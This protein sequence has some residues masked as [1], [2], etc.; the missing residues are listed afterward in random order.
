MSIPILRCG[1]FGLTLQRP[2]LMGVLNVTP[3]SF[4]DGG[5]FSEPAAAIDA[6]RRM[7]DEGA[8]LLDIGAESTRPGAAPVSADDE[9]R[10]LAPV[11]EALAGC[12]CPLSV[13]TRKPETM[14]RAIAAGCDLINDIG[15]FREPDAI[16]AVA[17]SAVAVCVMHM[18]GE[19]ATM[20]QAP[21]YRDVVA[22][23]R[24]FLRARVDALRGAG[25]VGPRILVDP[26]IGFGKTLEHNLELIR[27]LPA[28][29]EIAP[30]LVG[31]SRKS[32]IGALT[33]RDVSQRLPGS[34]AAMLAAVARGA[35]V[36]RVHDV[37]A[38]RDA[39]AVWSSIE[40]S[41]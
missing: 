6:A 25:V 34:L 24:E 7:I 41:R 27:R 10:R 13:D 32:M 40:G 37:A 36:V 5:R 2:L 23:V 8:D 38:S 19:P 31:V 39:L 33:G 21:E 28:L 12:G 16:A 18:R 30:V 26:G 20:Q 11:L 14:R 29:A 4:S 17:G 15:G 3:D 9:W 22:D 35:A 1:R